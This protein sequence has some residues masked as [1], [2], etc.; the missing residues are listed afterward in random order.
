MPSDAQRQA[1]L[2]TSLTELVATR[3]GQEAAMYGFLRDIFCDVLGYARTAVVAD[4]GG[5]RGRPDITVYAE[6]GNDGG[7]VSWIVL[8]AKA[9]TAL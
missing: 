9:S 8:E 4:V 3:R 6:G 1:I 2:T 7:R 5:Q